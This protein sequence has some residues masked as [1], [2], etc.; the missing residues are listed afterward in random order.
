M[1]LRLDRVRIYP[2]W[3]TGQLY[4]NGTFFC[5][6]LEDVVREIPGVPVEK[7]KIQNETAIPQGKY[8]VVLENSPK[9][10]DNTP[11]LVDVPGFKYIRVHSG[12]TDRDTDGCIIVGYSLSDQGIIVPGTSRPARNDLR[13]KL[14]AE[15]AKGKE[16]W[17]TITNILQ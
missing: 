3:T 4:V 9:F 7:W 12:N 6:T 11:T 17:I 16:I 14:I 13:E 15:V 5:F 1:N 2:K 8:R 10:G